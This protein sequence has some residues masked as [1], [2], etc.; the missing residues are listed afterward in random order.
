[1]IIR[2]LYHRF[3]FVKIISTAKTKKKIFELKNKCKKKSICYPAQ[4]FLRN[5]GKRYIYSYIK[6][7][8]AVKKGGK[9]EQL[10]L[11]DFLIARSIGIF[12]KVFVVVVGGLTTYTPPPLPAV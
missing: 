2:Q 1:M 10:K 8:T 11:K 12:A 7:K 6:R 9:K 4:D 5:E 3:I